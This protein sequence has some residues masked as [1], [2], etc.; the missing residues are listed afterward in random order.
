MSTFSADD[1][2]K[3]GTRVE[4]K[5]SLAE[6]AAGA[7]HRSLPG[8]K[9]TI[10]GRAKICERGP[11]KGKT[12]VEVRFDTR[13]DRLKRQPLRRNWWVRPENLIPLA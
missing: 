8:A 3:K 6:V 12:L 1:F 13:G 4:R 9:G 7:S 5:N 10:T 11:S 2:F